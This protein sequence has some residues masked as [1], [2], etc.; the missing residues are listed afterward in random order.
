MRGGGKED[1]TP[2]TD[3]NPEAC[4]TLMSR[5]LHV[6]PGPMGPG[7]HRY[8]ASCPKLYE[9]SHEQSCCVLLLCREREI[10]T[11]Y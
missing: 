9:R 10:T 6:G 11:P 1:H 5:T 2:D 7:T 8:D 3:D 4:C